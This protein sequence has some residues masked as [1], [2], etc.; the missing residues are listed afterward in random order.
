MKWHYIEHGRQLDI[1]YNLWVRWLNSNV[2]KNEV[3][4]RW[5]DSG[6]KLF[7]CFAKEEDATVFVLRFH[8]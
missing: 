2:G 7:I 8:I 6:G 3:D 4:W 5:D 1:T